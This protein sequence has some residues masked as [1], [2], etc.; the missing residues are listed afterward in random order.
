[1]ATKK[2]VTDC[3]ENIKAVL[4]HVNIEPNE[5]NWGNRP[6]LEDSSRFTAYFE[7]IYDALSPTFQKMFCSL[8][9]IHIE[10]K[11]PS[12]G[13]GGIDTKYGAIMGIRRSIIEK[14][15]N[16]TTWV[17]WKEQIMFGGDSINFNPVTDLPNYVVTIPDKKVNDFLFQ[18]II[19]EFG[20]LFD[21]ANNLNKTHNCIPE[22]YIP[23]ETQLCDFEDKTWGSISW[24]DSIQVKP[25]YDFFERSSLCFYNCNGNFV[26]RSS[27]SKIYQ[28]LFDSIFVSTYATTNPW[29]DFADALA[30]YAIDKY[31]DGKVVLNTGEGQSYELTSK[32]KAP[33][34]Q[35]KYKF[36]DDFLSRND[37]VY[38]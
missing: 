18:F 10:D 11:I 4:C 22:F 27:V 32:L 16:F 30:Y 28:G 17:S 36:I 7:N 9:K 33:I 1:M 19:H 38:P 23:G 24:R 12:S 26:N 13:Y 5:E 34:F 6:C 8:K 15:I 29:D 37:I 14:D 2:K 21:R 35:E 31:L 25:E 20:H 3:R